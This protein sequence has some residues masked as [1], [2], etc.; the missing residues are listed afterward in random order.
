MVRPRTGGWLSFIT[1]SGNYREDMLE[2]DLAGVQSIY[3]DRGFI[4]VR[5][6]KPRVEIS[7]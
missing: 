2:H 3:F 5:V 6:A 4:N 7:P 1:S